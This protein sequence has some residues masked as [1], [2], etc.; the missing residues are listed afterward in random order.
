MISLANKKYYEFEWVDGTVLSLPIPNQKL[1]QRM[2]K[3][4]N[5]EDEA[6]MLALLED[7]MKSIIKKNKEKKTISDDEFEEI[8]MKQL[9]DLLEDYM[10][11][12]NKELGE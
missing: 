3:L 8:D 6:E 11:F 5:T 12:V 9:K 2:M 4:D 1:L 10:A 7:V